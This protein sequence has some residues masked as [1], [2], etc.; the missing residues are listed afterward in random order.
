M[1][2]LFT[3]N[4]DDF[5]FFTIVWALLFGFLSIFLWIFIKKYLIFV[6]FKS[7][8]TRS[9]IERKLPLFESIFWAIYILYLLYLLVI[10]Y[11]LLG[12]LVVSVLLYFSRE[13]LSNYIKGLFYRFKDV[14]RVGQ[15]LKIG[16]DE[17]AVYELNN[18]ELVLETKRGEHIYYPY[19][20]LK[21]KQIMFLSGLHN[22]ETE[23]VKI[24]SSKNISQKE[25]VDFLNRL[26]WGV[27]AKLSDIQISNNK[28]NETYYECTIKA[29]NH[30]FLSYM[31]K[32]LFDFLK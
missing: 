20:N 1:K 4:I 27:R 14:F 23:V 7:R 11:P 22:Y 18:L 19:R 2:G 26:P 21:T 13:F 6:L 24:H 12:V 9:K 8:K 31:K 3:I 5:S 16:N 25:V 15:F 28:P 10:P 29:I 30:K 17:G 32:E